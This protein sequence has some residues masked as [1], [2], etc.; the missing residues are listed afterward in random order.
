VYDVAQALEMK[1]VNWRI[2]TEDLHRGQ[3][4][5][6]YDRVTLHPQDTSEKRDVV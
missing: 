4:T 6:T 3:H 1:D 5:L 2:C